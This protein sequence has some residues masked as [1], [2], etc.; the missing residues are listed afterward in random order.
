[1]S[2][3]YT[4]SYKRIEDKP[5]RF[6]IKA[7][8][9]GHIPDNNEIIIYEGTRVTIPAAKDKSLV[10]PLPLP[11]PKTPIIINLLSIKNL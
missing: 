8:D 2:S 3:N 6:I 1:M 11:T 4:N 9:W 7:P 5:K 10:K